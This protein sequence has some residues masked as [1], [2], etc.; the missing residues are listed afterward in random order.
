MDGAAVQYISIVE[1][2]ATTANVTRGAVVQPLYV[3]G[4]C[5]PFTSGRMAVTAGVAASYGFAVT[6]APLIAEASSGLPT[7]SG[8]AAHGSSC[9]ISI[10]YPLSQCSGSAVQNGIAIG[11][12]IHTSPVCRAATL[13]VLTQPTLAFSRPSGPLVRLVDPPV[14]SILEFERR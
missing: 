13:S 1:G 14:V 5:A 10:T 6:N 3:S 12:V 11:A 4:D 9:S 2:E 8:V 7:I